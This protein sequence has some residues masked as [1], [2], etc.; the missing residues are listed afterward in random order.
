MIGVYLKLIM[1]VKVRVRS[2]G[3]DESKI[4]SNLASILFKVIYSLF[5]KIVEF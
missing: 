2:Q 4:C 1:R 5:V 3:N